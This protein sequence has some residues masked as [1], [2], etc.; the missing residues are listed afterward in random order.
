MGS[1][2][3]SMKVNPVVYCTFIIRSQIEYSAIAQAAIVRCHGPQSRLEL[4]VGNDRKG[5]GSIVAYLAAIGLAFV[6]PWL[7][8]ALYALVALMWLVPD[9]RIESRLPH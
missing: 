2:I 6:S 4:A 7:S 5:K 1:Y 3:V 8:I 9:R